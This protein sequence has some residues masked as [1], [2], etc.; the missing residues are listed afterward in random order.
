VHQYTNGVDVPVSLKPNRIIWLAPDR[1]DVKTDRSTWLEMGRCLRDLGWT[2]TILTGR[3][4]GTHESLDTFGGLVEWV[5][6]TDVPFMF[7]LSLLFGMSRWLSRNVQADDVVVMNEDALWLLPHLKRLGVRFVHLDFRTL[8]VDL[9]RWKKRIDWLLSWRLA[10]K[11]FAQKADGYSFITE[12][13]RA[14]IEAEFGFGINDYAIW[15]SGVNLDRFSTPISNAPRGDDGFRLFYHGSISRRRGLG[16]VIEAIALGGFPPGFEFVIVGDGQERKDLE[17]QAK[18]LGVEKQVRFYGF[19][20]Y[21]RVASEIAHAD[22]CICPLPDR[23]EWNVSSPLKVFEYMACAKP[24]ILTPIPAH[25]DV[26]GE[27]RFV[28][29]T[30]GFEPADFHQAI[31]EAAASRVELTAQAALAPKLARVSYE[32]RVQANAFHRYLVRKRGFA[33]TASDDGTQLRYPG[34]KR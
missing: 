30:Q 4:G 20:P 31:L 26:L 21:E 22:V 19:V 16:L 25:R 29:W 32:W 11:R 2:V 8:P 34:A 27:S 7:R 17:R 24:M 6:A 5:P 15:H 14:E 12:R 3:R 28:V 1:F 33:S 13:L 18:A 23:L 9:H 10:I